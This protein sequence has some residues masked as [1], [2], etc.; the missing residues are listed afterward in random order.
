MATTLAVTFYLTTA[1][2]T[3]II[4]RIAMADCPPTAP[5]RCEPAHADV[6]I[7]AVLWPPI[8]LVVGLRIVAGFNDACEAEANEG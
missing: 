8:W 1:I 7:A 2:A 4:G 6:V 5:P 3:Y